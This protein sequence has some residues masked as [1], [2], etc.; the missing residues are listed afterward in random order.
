MS[1]HVKEALYVTNKAY[2]TQVRAAITQAVVGC[3]LECWLLICVVSVLSAGCPTSVQYQPNEGIVDTMGVAQA[4]Q[5]LQEIVSR[6][7]NPQV[8]GA[9]VTDDYLLYR[10]RQAVAGFPTGAILE[11]RLHFLNVSRTEVFENNTVNVRAENQTVLAQF[12]FGNNQ[13]AKMFADL[14]AS[15]RARQSRGQTR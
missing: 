3:R 12:V 1:H 14:L 7:I 8:T 5:R 9:E 4:R 15:F 13:D 2:I 6:S 11:N 10:Y